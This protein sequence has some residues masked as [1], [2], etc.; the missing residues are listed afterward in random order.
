M[1]VRH[2]SPVGI[3]IL[4]EQID[5]ANALFRQNRDFGDHI[6]ERTADFLASCIRDDAKRAIFAAAFHHRY[7]GFRTFGTR[8]RQGVEF[9]DFGKADIDDAL[10]LTTG[11]VKQLRQAV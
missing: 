11:F 9:F 1:A 10:M 6:V 7:E 4:S 8:F 5:F 2:Q 3:N